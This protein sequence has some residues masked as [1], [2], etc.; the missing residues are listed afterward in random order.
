MSTRRDSGG[1]VFGE[2]VIDGGLQLGDALEDAAADSLAG[3]LGEEALNEVQP[4]RRS[5]NEVQLEAWM[6]LQPRLNFLCLVRRV[7][8]D[9]EMEIEMLGYGPVDLLQEPDEFFGAMAGQTFADDLPV[10]TFKAAN[11]VVVPLRL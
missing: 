5:R 8:V 11:S 2:K 7:V 6:P 9:D 1:I 3:D 10:F 4:G